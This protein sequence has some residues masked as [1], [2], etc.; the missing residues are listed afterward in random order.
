MLQK[1][2]LTCVLLGSTV[3]T[4]DHQVAF[5]N[6]NEILVT[7]ISSE[8]R[9]HPKKVYKVLSKIDSII[10]Y[11]FPRKS[12]ILAIIAIESR[13]KSAAISPKGA[14]GLMQILYKNT[15]NDY[16]NLVAGI[17]LLKEYKELL[18]SDKAAVHAYNIGIG[19]YRKGVRSNNYYSK[20]LAAKTQF[21]QIA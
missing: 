17:K 9:V 7:H 3:P 12:D 20:Y 21:K 11:G 4:Y 8:Y 2:V 10:G 19:N 16:D 5:I 6:K 18:G 1:L 13:F 14:K 15:N